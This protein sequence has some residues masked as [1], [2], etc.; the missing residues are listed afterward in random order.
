MEEYFSNVPLIKIL[1]LNFIISIVLSI[2]FSVLVF[3]FAIGGLSGLGIILVMSI[4][5]GIALL[6]VKLF[7]W[8][9]HKFTKPQAVDLDALPVVMRMIITLGVMILGFGSG[10]WFIL[11]H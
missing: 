11:Y 7:N 9:L 2:P 8:L 3:A 1:I 10:L 6:I 4:P 5:F